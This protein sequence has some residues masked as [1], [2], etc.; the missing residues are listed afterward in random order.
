[1]ADKEIQLLERVLMKLA[2]TENDDLES[3]LNTFLLPVLKKLASP[4]H[5]THGKVHEVLQHILKRLKSLPSVKLPYTP[6]L[7]LFTDECATDSMRAFVLIF[8]SMAHT[9]ASEEEKCGSLGILLTEAAKLDALCQHDTVDQKVNQCASLFAM[10]FQTF[11]LPACVPRHPEEEPFAYWVERFPFLADSSLRAAILSFFMDMLMHEPFNE[12]PLETIEEST[13]PGLSL[14]GSSIVKACK[15]LSM[16]QWHVRKLNILR[17][18]NSRVFFTEQEILALNVVTASNQF[19]RINREGDL[20]MKQMRTIDME[21]EQVVERLI[22][23]YFGTSTQKKEVDEMETGEV[24]FELVSAANDSTLTEGE[25]RER[26]RKQDGELFNAWV[27]YSAR[28]ERAAAPVPV[29]CRVMDWLSRSNRAANDK[30]VAD[31][32]QHAVD[33]RDGYPGYTR[34]RQKGFL[35][36][37]W[38][39]QR[40]S[41]ERLHEIADASME[42]LEG[43]LATFLHMNGMSDTV[44]ATL[45]CIAE[46]SSRCPENVVSD[47]KIDLIIS[48]FDSVR[49]ETRKDVAQSM[50]DALA[51]MSSALMR[52]ETLDVMRLIPVLRLCLLHEDARIRHVVAL[53]AVRAFSFTCMDAR[54][55]CFLLSAD[56]TPE[57][58]SRALFGCTPFILRDGSLESVGADVVPYPSFDAATA[59][60]ADFINTAISAQPTALRQRKQ[61]PVK[62]QSFEQMLLF[63]E[64]ARDCHLKKAAP[65]EPSP[66]SGTTEYMESEDQLRDVEQSY[67]ELIELGIECSGL[68]SAALVGT[69]TRILLDLIKTS[70]QAC[71]GYAARFKWLLSLL[72]SSKLDAREHV[73]E[74]IGIVACHLTHDERTE[75]LRRLTSSVCAAHEATFSLKALRD[76]SRVHL[77]S[78]VSLHVLHGKV[79]TI[80]QICS[81]AAAAGTPVEEAVLRE[82]LVAVLP[83]LACHSASVAQATCNSL[84]AMLRWAT[85]PFPLGSAPLS[86]KAEKESVKV[87]QTKESGKP[88]EGSESSTSA[89]ACLEKPKKEESSE[90]AMETESDDATPEGEGDQEAAG[91]ITRHAV[92][93]ALLLLSKATEAQVAE[94]AIFAIGSVFLGE[95]DACTHY[96]ERVVDGLCALASSDHQEILFTIGDTLAS[97]ATGWS[98]V[99]C[100]SE[101]RLDEPAPLDEILTRVIDTFCVSG[102]PSDRRAGAT[103]LLCLLRR[104]GKHVVVQEQ[105]ARIQATFTDLLADESDVV[106]EIGSRGL[107]FVHEFGDASSRTSL[108]KT[109]V[110]TL[111]GGT[112]GQ[113][114]GRKGNTVFSGDAIASSGLST[115]QELCSVATEIGQPDMVYRLLSMASH[116]AM[117]NSRRGAAFAA[118]TLASSSARAELEQYLPSLVPKLYRSS[119]DPNPRVA[120]SMASILEELVEPSRILSEYWEQVIE[121]LLAGLGSNLWRVRESCAAATAAAVLGQPMAKL[122]PFLERLFFMAFRV[123]DDI[124]DSVRKEGEKCAKAVS[125]VT[126]RLCDPSYT[127]EAEAKRA[128]SLV[129]PYLLE[130][131]LTNDAEEVRKFA[132]AQVRK[133]CQSAGS[134]LEPH[135][136]Q[137]VAVL[138]ESLTMLEPQVFNYYAQ[139]TARLGISETKLEDARI[140]LAKLTPMT[141][142]L[143]ICCAHVVEENIEEVVAK[144]IHLLKHGVGL[145]AKVGT[146]KF[147]EDMVAKKPTLV[148][149]KGGRLLKALCSGLDDRSESVRKTYAQ[150]IG[151]LCA[152][153]AQKRVQGVVEHARDLY[154]D[155]GEERHRHVCAF[156][157]LQVALKASG[158]LKKFF[159]DVIPLAFLGR[160][161]PDD[162]TRKVFGRL[163]NEVGITQ[164]QRLYAQEV[165]AS[166]RSA[167]ASSSWVMKA[168]AAR[169]ISDFCVTA[170]KSVKEHALPLLPNLM[171]SLPGRIWTGKESLFDAIGA[172]CKACASD[173][174][175]PSE[176]TTAPSSCS[177]VAASS[178][179]AAGCTPLSLVAAIHEQ[180]NRSKLEYQR[181]AI[182]CLCELLESFNGPRSKE[183]FYTIVY[184]SLI[185]KLGGEKDET[186]GADED[187][188]LAGPRRLML[189]VVATKCLGLAWP[190]DPALGTRYVDGYLK[191]VKTPLA[192]SKWNVKEATLQSV[193]EVVRRTVAMVQREESEEAAV[194]GGLAVLE[195]IMC[196]HVIAAVQDSLCESKYTA[197][198]QA[199][200]NLLEAV[201]ALAP[202]L[203]GKVCTAQQLENIR[204]MLTT[205]GRDSNVGVQAKRLLGTL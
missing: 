107:V 6:L 72:G 123:M 96:G 33:F 161:D 143:N 146:A 21:S 70:K 171:E 43:S 179:A 20:F 178:D 69:S 12:A 148:K 94:A 174:A 156:V 168:Q 55:L 41:A 36:A 124:K 81:S 10:A 24:D 204:S 52:S 140:A 42:A 199:A 160:S 112:R 167:L 157:L 91:E 62:P 153:A 26:K 205:A 59:F 60:I 189:Q 100:A 154:F 202:R 44:I 145:P 65:S 162:D 201:L 121:D 8:L 53:F 139:H 137:I 85:L 198:R 4:H 90:D 82:A 187:D 92:V 2:M 49:S 14:L 102:R 104:V 88:K 11:E 50:L 158:A 48:L 135:V 15:K 106:Q 118:K 54:L 74:I 9:R 38:V 149:P 97:V 200:I 51:S 181:K 83:L 67:R 169:A 117:W 166:I 165:V 40:A 63:L 98:D 184:E 30:R 5:E 128:V 17:F 191:V 37:Q 58:A 89:P 32:I 173:L 188:K 101:V 134:L 176:A 180:S 182:T 127:S 155:K 177:A 195:Q 25:Q 110:S 105:L 80:G 109:L 113:K 77:A 18:A 56:H 108:V 22:G 27:T 61:L 141:D 172:L 130:R 57:V 138:I 151:A 86:S 163:W 193:R 192:L 87:E 126:I 73:S 125:N 115:Y 142:T 34:L 203:L 35:F 68:H 7:K 39:F 120:S 3:A 152:V 23:L 76:N 185:E 29:Q 1:M 119:F 196:D 197:L 131:G 66:E 45:K 47:A 129:L 71:K 31:I 103:W 136:P 116:H 28:N 150:C 159:S 170:P 93:S 164:P 13:A 99:Q 144:L 133:V 194:A 78:S 79:A 147:I 84:S 122:S 46:L 16:E 75:E 19:D 64:H 95:R 114:K 186:G 190:N 175:S 111:S 132:V 183:D